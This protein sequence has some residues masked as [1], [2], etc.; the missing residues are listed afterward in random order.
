MKK[1]IVFLLLLF[2]VKIHSQECR[3]TESSPFE[4]NLINYS[5]TN[6]KSY[7]LKIKFYLV[8]DDNGANRFDPILVNNLMNY[9]NSVYNEFQVYF[10]NNGV[11]NINSTQFNYLNYTSGENNEL[12]ASY[13][14]PNTINF[15][16]V[17]DISATPNDIAGLGFVKRVFIENAYVL[18]GGSIHELGHVLGLTHT[19]GDSTTCLVENASNC[20][21]CFD[22]LCDTNMSDLTNFMYPRILGTMNNFSELQ[23]NTVKNTIEFDT[24]SG[25]ESVRINY[26]PYI[27]KSN[28]L[29]NRY[30]CV[31]DYAGFDLV[32]N[33]ISQYPV[34]WTTSTPSNLT[35][36]SVYNNNRVTVKGLSNGTGTL[37]AT[38]NNT[39]ISVSIKIG[40]PTNIIATPYSYGYIISCSQPDYY[41]LE[42]VDLD[43][44]Q[45]GTTFLPINSL[46]QYSGSNFFYYVNPAHNFKFRLKNYYNC[47]TPSDWVNVTPVL[48]PANNYPLNLVFGTQN[49][50]GMPGHFCGY[51]QF[52]WTPISGATKYQVE[53]QGINLTNINQQ[54][55]TGTFQTTE[56]NT[57]QPTQYGSTSGTWI[58]KFRVKSQCING[59]WSDFSPWSA[60]FAW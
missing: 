48:C 10:V 45:S 38:F 54:V 4:S 44:N 2:F 13:T 35:I 22:K 57:T 37:T 6:S 8:G 24:S 16:I 60:N 49:T 11:T 21:T 40:S 18:T 58:I 7:T 50:C 23:K 5:N 30:V 31:N 56:S 3:Y 9:I 26:S 20:S 17:K 15:Y 41:Q 33:A 14:T 53:Y 32:G 51:G 34:T 39:S 42:Y 28:N 12:S 59:T 27:R 19:K 43:L 55:L 36:F 47:T 1:I 25:L 46:T 52:I 29:S